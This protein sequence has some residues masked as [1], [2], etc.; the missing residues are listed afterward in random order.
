[1][2][3]NIK[4]FEGRYMVSDDGR[5]KS[6]AKMK[7]CFLKEESLF[8]GSPDKNGYIRVSISDGNGKLKT[9]KVHRLVAEAFIP[10][11]EN[12]PQV[13]HKN[14]IKTD[15]RAK[16][17]EWITS[18]DNIRHA[19]SIGLREY[20]YQS[21]KVEIFDK[22]TGEK[23][24]FESMKDASIWLGHK[25]NYLARKVIN[26]KSRIFEVGKYVIKIA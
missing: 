18:A 17:L 4:G 5:V 26:N 11:P 1:M 23:F 22:N 24:L 13:N 25:R 21:R 14:G 12:L 15:N 3:K 16:N 8:N 7:G 9:V 6:L 20:H 19:V 10:N 2:W